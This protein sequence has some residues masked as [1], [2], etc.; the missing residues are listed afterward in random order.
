M[1][2]QAEWNSDEARENPNDAPKCATDKRQV[3][4]SQQDDEQRDLPK[5][6]HAFAHAPIEVWAERAVAI[7]GRDG[8][9]VE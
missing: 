7:E 8:Q 6:V 9:Q 2:G 4:E 3:P 1:H 5:A